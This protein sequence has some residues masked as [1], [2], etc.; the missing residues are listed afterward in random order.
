MNVRVYLLGTCGYQSAYCYRTT[1]QSWPTY[2][3]KKVITT[4]HGGSLIQI[5][6]KQYK[7]CVIV[8]K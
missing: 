6:L 4:I 1:K 5:Q 2:V 7:D 8:Y 3:N